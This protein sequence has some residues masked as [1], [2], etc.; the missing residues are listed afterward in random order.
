MNFLSYIKRN[1]KV[2]DSLHEIFQVESIGCFYDDPLY[3]HAYYL[4]A[5]GAKHFNIPLN[6][7]A[8][9]A[10]SGGGENNN[11]QHQHQQEENIHLENIQLRSDD[12]STDDTGG[13]ETNEEQK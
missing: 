8:Q 11:N 10:S 6:R 3:C 13:E 1:K 7:V 5:F 2:I 9:G 4:V 12:S